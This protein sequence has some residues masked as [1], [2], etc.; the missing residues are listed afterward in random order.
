MKLGTRDIFE[1]YNKDLVDRRNYLISAKENYE[2]SKKYIIDKLFE[3]KHYIENFTNINFKYIKDLDRYISEKSLIHLAQLPDVS[4]DTIRR[5][6]N[7]IVEINRSLI[8]VDLELE[9]LNSNSIDEN[10][11][12][13]IIA[14][15]NNKLSDEIVY[16]GYL[17]K[18]GRGLGVVRI[19]RIL[20]DKRIKKRINWNESNK[21][22]K[23]LLLQGEL[24]FQV[25]TRDENRKALTDNGG[26]P[27]FVYFEGDFDYL[28]H[29]SKNRNIVLNSA[30]YKFRPT[31]YNNTSKG[32]K[33]GNVNK[34]SHLKTS[35]SELLRNF[36]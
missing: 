4:I 19:K 35:N 34:L 31:I 6:L 13:N 8:K 25:L 36:S 9:E 2:R 7:V 27:W 24:P 16:K 10:V 3:Y 5:N 17:F 23:E 28:W 29:W 20:C 11:F 15:F 33:L 1:S 12:R 14:N 26:V 21:R 18:I 32:G 22:R 30:Y